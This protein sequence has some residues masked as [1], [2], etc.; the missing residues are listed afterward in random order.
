MRWGG[1]E[2]AEGGEGVESRTGVERRT[3][4]SYHKWLWNETLSRKWVSKAEEKTA[5]KKGGSGGEKWNTMKWAGWGWCGEHSLIS[6]WC[7]ETGRCEGRSWTRNRRDLRGK[8]RDIM[9]WG[10]GFWGLKGK[11]R[12]RLKSMWWGKKRTMGRKMKENEAFF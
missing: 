11:E 6:Y 1:R 7:K 9:E 8:K 4:K 10:N 3:R 12:E 5:G 2:T